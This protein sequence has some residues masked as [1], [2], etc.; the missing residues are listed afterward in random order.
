MNKLLSQIIA[1]KNAMDHSMRSS[2]DDDSEKFYASEFTVGFTFDGK[3][4]V[5]ELGMFSETWEMFENLVQD[6]GDMATDEDFYSVS[7]E[8]KNAW[9]KVNGKDYE[10]TVYSY[11]AEADTTFI[12]ANLYS[13][14]DENVYTLK[15]TKVVGFF[16]GR[17]TDCEKPEKY[18]GRMTAEYD[19]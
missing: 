19:L 17:K 2:F 7:E 15:R 4:N 8:D 9:L 3:K 13:K 14:N 1:F 16:H 5:V 11:S 6:M 12:T 18:V 10:E